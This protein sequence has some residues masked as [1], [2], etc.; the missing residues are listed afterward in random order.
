MIAIQEGIFELGQG[1]DQTYLSLDAINANI[2][3]SVRQM[4]DQTERQLKQ[5]VVEYRQLLE[6]KQSDTEK[7]QREDTHDH[8][9]NETSVEASNNPQNKP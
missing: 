6:Q 1:L 3:R 9:K 5:Q 2:N 7:K 8:R 4:S